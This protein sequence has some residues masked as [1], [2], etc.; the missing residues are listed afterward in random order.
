L[1]ELVK[2][3]VVFYGRPK[4]LV[5]SFVN[6]IFGLDR[7]PFF[8]KEQ[9]LHLSTIEERGEERMYIIYFS[10]DSFVR[11]VQLDVSQVTSSELNKALMKS[12]AGDER[13]V[14]PSR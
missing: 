5:L 9:L 10:Q 12:C 1:A 4:K 11:N 14:N 2:P 6:P 13:L 7:Q 8:A 3:P